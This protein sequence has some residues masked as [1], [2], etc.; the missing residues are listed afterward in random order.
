MSPQFYA[1][2]ASFIPD[3]AQILFRWTLWHACRE[4]LLFRYPY[5]W[6]KY[7]Q[8]VAFFYR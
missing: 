2:L 6:V 8:N 5:G 3:F 4:I 1:D 7:E